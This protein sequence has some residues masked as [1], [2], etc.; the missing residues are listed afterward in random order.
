MHALPSYVHFERSP[1]V[2]PILH[3]RIAQ[4]LTPAV[5]T[6][7]A[8]QSRIVLPR[9]GELLLYQ[10]R[11]AWLTGDGAP[12]TFDLRNDM[13]FQTQRTNDSQGGERADSRE[14]TWLAGDAEPWSFRL[15]TRIPTRRVPD[16]EKRAAVHV[17]CEWCGS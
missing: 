4:F 14:R 5:A 8:R 7:T 3:L 16:T 13:Q 17:A 11:S 9:A 2:P 1:T 15:R 10:G 12:W 6:D